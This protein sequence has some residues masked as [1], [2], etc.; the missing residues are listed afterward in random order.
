[1][2]RIY[3]II[4]RVSRMP[5]CSRCPAVDNLRGARI[6]VTVSVIDFPRYDLSASRGFLVLY[7]PDIYMSMLIMCP[8]LGRLKL[9]N[10]TAGDIERLFQPFFQLLFCAV[11]TVAIWKSHKT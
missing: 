7:R 11:V 10:M 9:C 8:C 3:L 2:K 6:T 4:F 5:I 1:M